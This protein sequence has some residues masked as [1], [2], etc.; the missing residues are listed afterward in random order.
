LGSKS[1]TAPSVAV[2]FVLAMV[3]DLDGAAVAIFALR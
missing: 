3:A 1:G 2:V